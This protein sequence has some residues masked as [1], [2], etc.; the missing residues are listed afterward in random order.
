MYFLFFEICSNGALLQL[1]I[2][3]LFS[4]NIP[5]V[6]LFFL[7]LQQKIIFIHAQNDFDTIL[8][9][10]SSV[11]IKLLQHSFSLWKH[12]VDYEVSLLK[13]NL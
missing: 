4:E 12:Y 5:K 9:N 6:W 8:T 3:S 1:L 13:S 11:Q 10:I 7:L 2:G